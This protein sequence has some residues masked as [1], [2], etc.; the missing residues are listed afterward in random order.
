[1]ELGGLQRD[2]GARDKEVEG[3]ALP[4]ASKLNVRFQVKHAAEQT[5][6]KKVVLRLLETFNFVDLSNIEMQPRGGFLV[7]H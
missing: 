6:E 4:F 2:R 3:G 7:I 5:V 1:M